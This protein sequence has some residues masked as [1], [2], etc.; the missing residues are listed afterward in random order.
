[1]PQ[2]WYCFCAVSSLLVNEEGCL[3]DAIFAWVV[4]P[5]IKA[6][7][8][9]MFDTRHS[10]RNVYIIPVS[11]EM[12]G[13]RKGHCTEEFEPRLHNTVRGIEVLHQGDTADTPFIKRIGLGRWMG[14]IWTGFQ[15]NTILEAF[16]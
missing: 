12:G 13:V 6:Q 9:P 15:A 16:L 2:Q 8:T 14:N 11:E 3:E 10:P 1:M 5:L 7:I 4:I